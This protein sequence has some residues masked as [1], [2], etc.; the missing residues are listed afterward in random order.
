VERRIASRLHATGCSSVLNYVRLL[1]RDKKEVS[2]LYNALTINVSSF[3]RNK[4]VFDFLKEHIFPEIVKSKI[5]SGENAINIWSIGCS[6]GEEPY[7]IA[8]LIYRY[9]RIKLQK[10]H[11]TIKAVDIDPKALDIAK[12]GVYPHSKLENLDPKIIRS[13]FNRVDE[14][15]QLLETIREM[16]EFRQEDIAEFKPAEMVF[17]LIL[18]RNML[19]YFNKEKHVKAYNYFLRHLHTGGYL[20]LGKAE[21][22]FF[23]K[24]NHFNHVSIKNRVYQ[25]TG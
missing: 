13:C 22:M 14:R 19:I 4:E 25:K 18:C 6:T 24:E 17:D 7:S 10:F 21:V 12:S 3:F 16:V 23:P 1:K 20:I 11:I 9:L 8:I 2:K 15:Y 5:K